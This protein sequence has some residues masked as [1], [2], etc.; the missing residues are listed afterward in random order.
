MQIQP[1]REAFAS[2]CQLG[3]ELTG[4]FKNMKHKQIND[5][6]RLTKGLLYKREPLSVLV[7]PPCA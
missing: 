3:K 7:R 5:A 4:V 2:D 1:E 6:D